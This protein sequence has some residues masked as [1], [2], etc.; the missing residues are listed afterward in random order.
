M[1]AAATVVHELAELSHDLVRAV[2]GHDLDRLDT[3]LAREFTLL[4]AAGEFDRAALLEAAAG[5]Y[6]IEEFAYEEIDPQVYGDTALVVSRYEQTAKLDGRDVS[7]RMHVTDVWVR[8]DGRWQIVRRHA[9]MVD[10][11]R[12]PALGSSWRVT[13][14]TRAARRALARVGPMLAGLARFTIRHRFVVVGVWAVLLVAGVMAAGGCR[15][16]GSRRSRFPGFSA[17]QANQRTLKTFGSGEQ[18]PVVVVF[19]TP[20]RDVT[21]VDGVDRRR[22]RQARECCRVDASD[23]GMRRTATRTCRRIATR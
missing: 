11:R 16:A 18:P 21:T 8:R 7:A 15:T 12:V 4:G 6:V 3:L 23:R 20:S 1:S 22:S 14:W 10:P 19:T 2:Q 13:T 17:Y 5:A 9:T